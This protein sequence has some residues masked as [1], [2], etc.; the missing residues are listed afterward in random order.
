MFPSQCNQYLRNL[1]VLQIF[2]WSQSSS[3]Y[4]HFLQ[5]YNE[6]F[7]TLSDPKKSTSTA[8]ME[9]PRLS[10]SL[11]STARIVCPGFV[12]TTV[13]EP[14]GK[15]TRQNFTSFSSGS[16]SFACKDYIVTCE[17]VLIKLIYY[18]T[19]IFHF[20]PQAQRQMISKP[21]SYTLLK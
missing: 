13:V 14:S 12:H 18:M 3:D 19:I 11:P 8:A 4:V 20:I 6:E 17:T 15:I 5:I 16:F 9:S 10:H 1:G 21:M 7:L 2:H